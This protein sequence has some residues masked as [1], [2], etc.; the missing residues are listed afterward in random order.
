M[1]DEAQLR[2]DIVEV[3]RRLWVRGFVASND[4]NIS[5]RLDEKRLLM[6]PASVSKGFM[7]PDMMVITDLD[8]KILAGAPGR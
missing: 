7:T 5:V 6:T 8:G 2:N 3:G 1:Q 4:G